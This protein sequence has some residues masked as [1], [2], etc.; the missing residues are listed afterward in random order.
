MFNLWFLWCYGSVALYLNLLQWSVWFSASL[1]L[2]FMQSIS[3]NH[4]CRHYLLYQDPKPLFWCVALKLESFVFCFSFG[5]LTV[6][7][8]FITILP[9]SWGMRSVP[10]TSM[11]ECSTCGK[12]TLRWKLFQ[13]QRYV[14]YG[15][16]YLWLNEIFICCTWHFQIKFLD[17][18]MNGYQTGDKIW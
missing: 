9:C 10:P 18:S 5:N 6:M 8:L 1:H 4:C 11:T 17:W 14:H 13:K 15:N 2:R 16:K 12:K 3:W 7:L